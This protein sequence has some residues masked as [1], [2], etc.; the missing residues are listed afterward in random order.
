MKRRLSAGLSA[1]SAIRVIAPDAARIGG[2]YAAAA[3]WV[4]YSDTVIMGK[5]IKLVL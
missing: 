4:I 5:L 3:F 1:D 2:D